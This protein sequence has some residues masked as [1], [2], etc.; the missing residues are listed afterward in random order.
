ME[1]VHDRKE[2]FALVNSVSERNRDYF[3]RYGSWSQPQVKLYWI[4]VNDRYFKKILE[5]SGARLIDTKFY[6]IEHENEVYWVDASD[7]RIW[8]I[9]TYAETKK[10]DTMVKERILKF[11]GADNVWLPEKFMTRIQRDM[12]YN[13]RGFGIQYKDI[14]SPDSPRSDFSAKLWVGK[15]HSPKQD[16]F[17]KS[18]KD[19]F[20]MSSVRF[21]KNESGDGYNLSGQLYE[22]YYNGHMTVNTCD[23]IE[24]MVA[25]YDFIRSTYRNEI[26]HLET[27]NKKR[28]SFIEILFSDNIERDGFDFRTN[29]GQ[30]KLKLWLQPYQRD[31]DLIR[32]SG[33][34]LHTG[35][36]VQVDL[37]DNYSYVSASPG[38]CMNVAPRFGTLA[39]RYMSSNVEILHEGVEMFA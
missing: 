34:D 7:S 5:V 35:D 18:V 32:Y 13:D 15:R 10:A 6:E 21:G 8:Q 19:I 1:K 4:E 16:D 24:E 12:G 26:E 14:L 17:L 29:N 36:F 9:F 3:S 30:G 28:A 2:F 38:S 23:S 11:K 22:L 31:G 33:V 25:L 39:A 37:S 27:E 20:S